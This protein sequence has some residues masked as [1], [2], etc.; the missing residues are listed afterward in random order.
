MSGTFSLASLCPSRAFISCRL[1][2][3]CCGDTVMSHRCNNSCLCKF[4][5]LRS[6]SRSVLFFAAPRVLQL[7]LIDDELY[8][9]VA[10]SGSYLVQ[11]SW[12]YLGAK[13]EKAYVAK[14]TWHRI[15]KFTHAASGTYSAYVYI[16]YSGARCDGR[17]IY[18][19][20]IY[21]SCMWGSL[22][23]APIKN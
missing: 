21:N 2:S 22:R 4:H 18:E 11:R 14:T 17:T 5:G 12:Q 9:A 1:A 13:N 10:S 23:L 8:L 6:T 20:R 16:T 7:T 19:L 15:A 3:L